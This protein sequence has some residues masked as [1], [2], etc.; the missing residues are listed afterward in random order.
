MS[1]QLPVMSV[2]LEDDPG[3]HSRGSTGSASGQSDC[4]GYRRSCPSLFLIITFLSLIL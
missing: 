1:A 2:S 3:F 4:T